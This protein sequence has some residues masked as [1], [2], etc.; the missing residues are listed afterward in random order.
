MKNNFIPCI[1]MLVTLTARRLLFRPVT[2]FSAVSWTSAPRTTRT[3]VA[4]FSSADS[5]DANGA[6]QGD[7]ALDEY[8]NKNNVRD[9]VFSAISKDGSVKVTAATVRNI[10]NDMMIMHTMSEVS[11]D[12]MGRLVSCAVL[13][14]NGMQEEQTL[15]ITMNGDGPL[16]GAMAIS[17]GKG[18]VRGY[19]GSP[20]IGSMSLPEAVGKGAVAVVKNHPD[21]PNPY[22]GITA[23][24]HGD[25]DRDIGKSADEWMGIV[26]LCCWVSVVARE[27][28][29]SYHLFCR[30]TVGIYLAESEQRSCALAAATSINGILCK[31]AGGYLVEKL[32]DCSEETIAKVEE[33]LGK[34]VEMDGGD[35]L[36]TNLLL[37]GV[38]PVE[39]VATILDG[40]EMQ[41]LQ[42]IEPKYVCECTE[43]RLFRAL[44]L[45]PREEVD[46]ILEKEQQIE[47]R[48]HFCGKVYRMTPEEVEERFEAATGDPS[49]D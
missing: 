18:S 16:R 36:P 38:T 35:K 24:R 45:L 27:R 21:W 19:A 44:R 48:C 46:E 22:N 26:L 11:A 6:S 41:P 47:A 49:R 2:A 25:I 10:V 7:D 1:T 8:K 34:L 14:S 42:Q 32:P 9:Q 20:A 12:A 3:F 37:Q 43:D 13:I 39:I 28:E 40:L 29:R 30:V 17:S 31:A 33:N 5:S 23:I 4:R 15:Q